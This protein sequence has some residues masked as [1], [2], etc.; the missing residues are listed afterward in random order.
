MNKLQGTFAL[1]TGASKGLGRAIAV[2]LA[3][4]GYNLLLIARS[5]KELSKLSDELQSNYGVSAINFPIDLSE[6]IAAETLNAWIK[7]NDFP[8]SILINNAGYGLW[9]K[10]NELSIS[11][12]I[13]MCHLNIDV[14]VKL[15]HFLIPRLLQAKEA[16]ILNVSSTAAYQAV[17]TLAIYAATKSFVLSFSRALRFELKN[18]SVSVSCLSPGPIDTGF[19]ERAGLDAFSKMAEKFNMK[20]EEVAKI[21]L[22]GLFAKK[23]EI[24]PGATNWISAF[25]NR[26]LPK[27]FIEKMAA[28]IYKT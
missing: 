28:G 8:I 9:G 22:D 10:F 5:T 23:S 24:I 25:A 17:P 16:Y 11:A 13:D 15:S 1:V 4:K 2:D 6:D 20:P 26:I 19:A 27:A 12:Q 7:E 18:S 3:K 21:A 14:L